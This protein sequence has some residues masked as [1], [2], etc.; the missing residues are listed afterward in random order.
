MKP[1]FFVIG[2]FNYARYGLC[3]IN[4]MEK[5]PNEAL[6][7]SMK[8]EHVTRHKRGM[9]NLVWSDMMIETTYMKFGK[10][11]RGIIGVKTQPQTLNVWAKS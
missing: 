8:R 7:S 5:L 2:H 4:S 6:E 1:Y 3:Y 11:L 9:W 10:G